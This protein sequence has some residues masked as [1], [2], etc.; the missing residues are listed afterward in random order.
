MTWTQWLPE[1]A[2][3]QAKEKS[4]GQFLIKAANYENSYVL[5]DYVSKLSQD[6]IILSSWRVSTT[7]NACVEKQTNKK[8]KRSK[9]G[10]IVVL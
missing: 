5:M 6:I 2:P 1:S 8:N 4:N 3:R 9:M 7:G 10:K